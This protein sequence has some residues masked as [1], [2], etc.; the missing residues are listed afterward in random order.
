MNETG[1]K[2][3]E[4]SEV[5]KLWRKSSW[6]S[7]SL[8]KGE[9]DL[10]EG[11]QG[12]AILILLRGAIHFD[13]TADEEPF[14]LR[15][16]EVCLLST[17]SPYK[18]MVEE[19]AHLLMCLFIT[20]IFPFDRE[21]LATLRPF[22]RRGSNARIVLKMNETIGAFSQLMDNYIEKGLESDPL[23]EIKRQELFLLL[24]ATYS[25]KELALFFC[26]IIG[27]GIQFKE[28]VMGNYIKAKNVQ[29]LAQMANNSTSGF[30]KKFNRHF[31]ESPYRWMLRHKAKV[32]LEDVRSSQTTLK[33]IAFKY[34]F[35]DYQHF[36]GFCKMQ[37]GVT[38]SKLRFR[39]P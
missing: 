36:V 15:A 1:L 31:K 3:R 25:A 10:G 37:Y 21:M 12:I 27:E 13:A 32:I 11:V 7:Y 26:P 2:N 16:Q 18:A 28:F 9:T 38:P 5:G 29:H 23:F 14:T 39:V 17:T 4:R 34:N 6:M 24:F 20:D 30:I 19:D 35:S 8:E 22:Y 33:E